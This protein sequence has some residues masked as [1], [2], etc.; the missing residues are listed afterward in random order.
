VLTVANFVTA[1]GSGSYYGIKA[2][3]Y[4]GA[5]GQEKF[6]A[7]GENGKA[8]YSANG[9]E[10]KAVTDTK[11]S[12]D[13][14]AIAYGGGKFVAV[15]GDDKAAYSA[16]GVSWT[17]DV[18]LHPNLENFAPKIGKRNAEFCTKKWKLHNL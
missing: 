4:G 12:G 3:A 14:K 15:G 7:V 8:A 5:T 10:W 2:I 11:I 6:V 9:E 17:V 13:I 16:D 1:S 18:T